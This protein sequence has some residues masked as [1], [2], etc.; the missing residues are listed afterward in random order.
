MEI[1]ELNLDLQRQASPLP[2]FRDTL[3]TGEWVAL[4]QTVVSLGG[5]LIALWGSAAGGP[6]VSA[7]YGVREG[8]GALRASR[9]EDDELA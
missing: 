7:A 8:L 5:R 9:A 2:I 6:V 1:G 4:A 3:N